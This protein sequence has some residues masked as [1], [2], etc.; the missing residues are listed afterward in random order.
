MVLI[1]GGTGVLGNRV[2]RILLKRGE[3]VRVM[4]R[5]SDGKRAADLRG[6]GAEVVRGDV[7][8]AASVE[9]AVAGMDTV[10]ISVQ[11][12]AGP[13]ATRDN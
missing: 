5:D 9:A 2:A 13:N 3:R 10:V 7:R 6:L 11:A 1:A 4:T 12:L 8:D